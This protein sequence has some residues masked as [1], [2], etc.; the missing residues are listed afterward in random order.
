[1]SEEAALKDNAAIVFEDNAAIVFED[2]PRIPVVDADPILCIYKDFDD[3]SAF[4]FTDDEILDFT[5]REQMSHLFYMSGS[6]TKPLVLP[7]GFGQ[8]ATDLSRCFYNCK[9][10]SLTLPDGFGQNA[11][12]LNG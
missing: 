8:S 7:D 10:Q 11:T 6:K 3:P 9:C 4:E 2:T 12:D 5:K 1:M